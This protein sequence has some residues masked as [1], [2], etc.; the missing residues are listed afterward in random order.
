MFKHIINNNYMRLLT[1]LQGKESNMW[2]LSRNTGINYYFLTGRIKQFI[3]S[4]I[5]VK[6]QKG[7]THIISLSEKGKKATQKL[8]E[9]K[10]IMEEK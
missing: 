4:G 2:E 9:I 5:I 7:S 1:Y 3:D 10:N 8:I 6:K